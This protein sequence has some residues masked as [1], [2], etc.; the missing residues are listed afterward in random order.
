MSDEA[1]PA[2]SAFSRRTLA[3]T[4]AWAVP[5]VVIST[6]MPAFA[7]SAIASGTI[8]LGAS[9]YTFLA[10]ETLTIT[11]TVAALGGGQ[12]PADLMLTAS[13]TGGFTVVGQPVITG[14]TFTLTVT[15][16]TSGNPGSLTVA[17]AN[18]PGYAPAVASLT[19]L[20]A[21]M[22]DSSMG[23]V[24]LASNWLL[25]D[26]ANGIR[27]YRHSAGAIALTAGQLNTRLLDLRVAFAI[28]S[29]S[30]YGCTPFAAPTAT[31]GYPTRYTSMKMAT[32]TTVVSARVSG[33]VRADS[34]T[35]ATMVQTTVGKA[36]GTGNFTTA[37]IVN[38]AGT[39]MPNTDATGAAVPNNGA[40][41][42]V[43]T[44]MPKASEATLEVV[45]TLS[46]DETRSIALGFQIRYSRA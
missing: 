45:H 4:A 7:A 20:A 9:S 43:P 12:L 14:T 16:V 15:A 36:S 31:G 2:T 27:W 39:F 29:S 21:G 18:Y 1:S 44:A 40:Y 25:A 35:L 6:A 42:L 38:K 17:S 23:L 11:G 41:V 46:L 33:E 5:A 37:G 22:V 24:P 32:T 3:K 30:N 10:I 34:A 13:A 26:D 28:G 8:K 19:A